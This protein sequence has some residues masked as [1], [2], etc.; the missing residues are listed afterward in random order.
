MVTFGDFNDCGSGQT[1]CVDTVVAGPFLAQAG[2]GLNYGLTPQFGLV[3]AS[4]ALVAA[5]NFT[6]H[7]D[8]NAGISYT[9]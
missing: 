4:N 2:G 1:T 3:L 9:F 6:V 7:F 5:P 8:I